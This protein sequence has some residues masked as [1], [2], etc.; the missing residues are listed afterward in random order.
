MIEVKYVK[1]ENSKHNSERVIINNI[2]DK[3]SFR[4]LY[5]NCN[6]ISIYNDEIISILLDEKINEIFKHIDELTIPMDEKYYPQSIS[7]Y[8]WSHIN[9]IKGNNEY[10]IEFNFQYD[11]EV[12]KN[13]Y[14]LKDFTE[15]MELLCN[16]DKLINYDQDDVESIS[17]GFKLFTNVENLDDSFG[18]AIESFSIK[19]N[20]IFDKVIESQFKNNLLNSINFEFSVSNDIKIVCEQYLT[21]FIQFLEDAGI[22]AN[23][24]ISSES[25]KILFSVIPNDPNIALE[26]IKEALEV[27]L[28]LPRYLDEINK[29]NINEIAVL[30]LQSN[31]SHLNSQLALAK[32]TMIAQ[33][34]TIATLE[35]ISTEKVKNVVNKNEE[36]IFN[37]FLT[38]TEYKKNGLKINLPEILRLLK[39]KFK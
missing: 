20:T 25:Q 16:D 30:Q 19:V 21:Y 31:I 28:Q 37:G 14:T 29:I 10:K 36:K 18:N 13:P 27:Y 22:Q 33:E 15:Q 11:T 23:S 24:K 17:N 1:D 3:D 38:V 2:Y 35:L 34:K 12:W 5:R 6:I 32:A 8:D 7:E 26:N 39:R 9:L 4:S